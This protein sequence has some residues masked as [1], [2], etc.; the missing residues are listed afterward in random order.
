[1]PDLT[2][3]RRSF[4]APPDPTGWIPDGVA[5][6]VLIALAV[7]LAWFFRVLLRIQDRLALADRIWILVLG[8]LLIEVYVIRRAWIQGARAIRLWRESRR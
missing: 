5:A 1:M 8:F 2:R 7:A 6:V 4:A 3:R